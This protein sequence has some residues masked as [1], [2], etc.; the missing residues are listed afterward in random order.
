LGSDAKKKGQEGLDEDLVRGD[1]SQ[2]EPDSVSADESQGKGAAAGEAQDGDP[3]AGDAMAEEN[4]PVVLRQILAEQLSQA[5]EYRDRL[6]RLQADYDNFRRRSR[7]EKEEIYKYTSVKMISALLPV[8]DNFE[9]ALSAEGDSIESFKSGV[10]MIYKLLNDVLA[11]E[12]VVQI[13]SVGEQFDPLKHEAVLRVDSDEYPD[14]TIIEEFRRG[15]YIKDKVIR[16]SMV[17]VVKSI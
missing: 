16:P 13:L 7:Q 8:L 14:N 11:A 15:Y 10:Q 4:D 5:E 12:G 9:L 17:K 1:S 2:N 3:G 6:V